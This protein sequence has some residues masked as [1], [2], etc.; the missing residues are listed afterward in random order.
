MKRRIKTKAP[1]RQRLSLPQAAIAQLGKLSDP[2]IAAQY[3]I[4]VR[5]VAAERLVRGIA[6]VRRGGREP[7]AA[8]LA[9]T[10]RMG[11][12]LT[13]AERAE[14][15]AAVPKGEPKARWVVD[16][17]LERARGQGKD[18]DAVELELLAAK[19]RIADLEQ[20]LVTANDQ[21]E[22]DAHEIARLHGVQPIPVMTS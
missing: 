8:G 16:A 20:R 5:R 21:A 1:T 15:V 22:R 4:N 11:L 17:A 2:E 14:I 9:Q 12:H 7:K 3:G 13:T 10:E 6:R 18:I 19:E